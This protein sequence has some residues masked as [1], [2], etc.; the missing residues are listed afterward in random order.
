VTKKSLKRFLK[1]LGY[2]YKRARA[3]ITKCDREIFD[4]AKEEIEYIKEE[5]TKNKNSEL[6]F[7]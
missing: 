3:K 7:F 2:S 1:S 4:E 5:T 6:Y